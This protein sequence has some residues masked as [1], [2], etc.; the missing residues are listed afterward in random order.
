MC[1]TNDET[2]VHLLLEYPHI[3]AVWSCIEHMLTLI[4]DCNVKLDTERVI[5]GINKK[6]QCIAKNYICM[7]NLVILETKWAIWKHRNNVKMNQAQIMNIHVL[8]KQI[9]TS[10]KKSIEILFESSHVKNRKSEDICV[11][12]LSLKD[13]NIF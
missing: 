9:V 2:L 4:T 11:S 3:K 7:Y 12:L 10:C 6:E 8:C 1:K 5:F 13:I